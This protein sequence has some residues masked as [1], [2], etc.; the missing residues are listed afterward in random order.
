MILGIPGD[1]TYSNYQEANRALWKLTLLP[2][3]EQFMAGLNSW[4]VPAFGRD[5]TL[6]FDRDEIPAIAFERD[7]LWSRIGMAPFLTPNEKRTLLGFSPLD[8]AE[9]ASETSP[10]A[11]EVKH[12][13]KKKIGGH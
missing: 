12:R 1:N 4:L 11:A 5:L 13:L 10:S 7:L 2:L 8:E 6:D 9:S 3:L